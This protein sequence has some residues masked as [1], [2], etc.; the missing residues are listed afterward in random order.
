[1]TT[2]K[3]L[4]QALPADTNAV[5]I[6]SPPAAEIITEIKT[7]IVTNVTSS[8]ATCR[9]F[10]D[11]NGTTYSTATALVYDKTVLANDFFA[12]GFGEKDEGIWFEDSTGNLAIQSGTGSALN[13]TVY[14]I[15][16]NDDRDIRN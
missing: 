4:G 9:I 13:F 14:G 12:I 16:N 8:N 15:E 6:Y 3:Q 2:G 5:S 10:H 11:D 1:M 7:I